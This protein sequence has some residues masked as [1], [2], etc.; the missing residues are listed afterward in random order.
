[1]LEEKYLDLVKSVINSQENLVVIFDKEEILLTNN[2]FNHFFGASSLDEYKSNFGPFLD[3]FVPHPSYFN[4]EKITPELSWFESIMN[5]PEIDRVV[6]ILNQNYEP[7]AFS[8]NVDMSLGELKVV[9]FVNITQS[10]IKR[11]MIENNASVDAKSGAYSKSYF[12]HIMKS[13][14]DASL[15]NE[16]IIGASAIEIK[17]DKEVSET[18]LREFVENF[19]QFIREDDM[20]I[21]WSSKQ[22]LLIYL[23]KDATTATKVRS[24]LKSIATNKTISGVSYLLSS[25]WQKDKESITTLLSRLKI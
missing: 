3:H 10:L 23:A 11:L 19:K 9:T 22:F 4:K 2:S 20:L 21:R 8:V 5:L 15:F 12:L 25:T 17:S 24:K 16:K 18:T 7:Q 1:M 13:Y 14:E 6:S